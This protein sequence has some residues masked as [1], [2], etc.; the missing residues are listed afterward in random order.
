MAGVGRPP[1]GPKYGG[2]Q[3]GSTDKQKRQIMGQQLLNAV[4]KAWKAQG[5]DY[6]IQFAKDS[7]RDFIALLLT[8]VLPQP[9]KDEPDLQ[10]NQQFNIGD[11]GQ[12]G[13]PA[14]REVARRIAFALSQGLQATE[15]QQQQ[16]EPER[17]QRV[18]EPTEYP[19]PRYAQ[20][21]EEPAPSR[22]LDGDE[23]DAWAQSLAL[24]EE[25]RA[26]AALARQGHLNLAEQGR[27]LLP[28][29][30]SEPRRRGGIP[31]GCRKR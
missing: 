5:P 22:P 4:M 16:P 11:L 26:D 6:L 30:P 27:S 20:P 2:R 17:V 8:R 25:Q 9:L 28:P 3:K 19:A 14:E 10:V 23:Y 21:A 29:E 13:M 18:P 7:P 12:P 31:P 15:Q 24:P 1:G